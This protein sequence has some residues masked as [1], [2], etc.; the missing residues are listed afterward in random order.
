MSPNMVNLTAPV[1]PSTSA[2]SAPSAEGG[3]AG[4]SFESM[5]GTSI[6]T[7][8]RRQEGGSTNASA[9][10]EKAGDDPS[11]EMKP[12]A[13]AVKQAGEQQ[14]D[15]AARDLSRGQQHNALLAQL[16]QQSARQDAAAQDKDGLYRQ[17][18]TDAGGALQALVGDKRLSGDVLER[19]LGRAGQRGAEKSDKASDD[20]TTELGDDPLLG[21]LVAIP[22]SGAQ[23][24][25]KAVTSAAGRGALDAA[26]AKSAHAR[27]SGKDVLADT[28]L[29][30]KGQASE[31]N[32]RQAFT[33]NGAD[34]QF[35]A[36]TLAANGATNTPSGSSPDASTLVGANP[37]AQV[38]QQPTATLATASPA[39]P[40]PAFTATLDAPLGSDPWNQSLGQQM[41]R[42]SHVGN[43][44][45]ELFL[46]PPD[47]G[48]LQVTLKMGEQA[49]LHFAS[50]HAQVRA[51]VEAALPQLRDA[52]ADS[53]I[54]LGQ[55]SV[56][57]QG[58]GQA[59]AFQQQQSQSRGASMGSRYGD[60]AGDDVSAPATIVP[61]SGRNL[62]GGIDI[63]A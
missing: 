41:L 18:D 3:D 46:N 45:A 28:A 51:A 23:A 30:A 52:F 26:Q 19:A 1:A 21:A 5:L 50:P 16:S 8:S 10:G 20:K 32:D 2:S 40:T 4:S 17:V 6:A 39:S 15:R 54:N 60:L 24:S 29:A 48:Q 34:A 31:R 22:V 9:A 47:L 63:F 43:G 57:D 14:D 44:Q 56:S 13:Q 61:I 33:L 59:F 35:D 58:N 37:N 11:S 12:L 27:D 49:Q 25:A 53:G 42:L 36:K 55:T 7:Q 38:T 62:S